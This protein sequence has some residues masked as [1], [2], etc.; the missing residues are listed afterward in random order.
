MVVGMVGKFLKIKGH[1]YFL[2]MAAQI[3][4][5]IPGAV[6]YIIVGNAESGQ[7]PYRESIRI[8]A[9][10]LG[11]KSSITIFTDGSRECIPIALSHMDIFIQMSMYPEG[12]GGVVLEAMAMALPV[13]AFDCGGV[14]E[15]F[16]NGQS[17]FLIRAADS[18]RAAEKV[19]D[20]LT[21]PALRER[22]GK[23]AARDLAAKFS[24]EKHF[25]EIEKVYAEHYV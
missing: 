1:R 18:G 17:G 19:I 7:E 6:H 5:T 24:Y 2:D 4:S 3:E 16:V 21:D 12:L 11:L 25:S 20:L 13:V 22:M 10:R 23:Q 8:H 15:C 9:D 14:G